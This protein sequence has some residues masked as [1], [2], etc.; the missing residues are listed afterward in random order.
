M[1]EALSS[2]HRRSWCHNESGMPQERAMG[3]KRYRIV[4]GGELSRCF[5]PAFE[6]MTVECAGGQTVIT[7]AVLDQSHLHGL[8]GRIGELGL[9]LVSVNTIAEA[10]GRVDAQLH[11]E[12]AAGSQPAE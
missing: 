4:V 12:D 1:D 6:G 9:D 8:L 2:S 5:A 11:R 3:P 10:E 7:G